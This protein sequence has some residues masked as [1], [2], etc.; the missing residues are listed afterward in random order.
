MK[1]RQAINDDAEE[2][3]RLSGQLGYPV[4]AVVMLERLN[5][6]CGDN[7]HIAYAMETNSGL[8]GWIHAQVRHTLESAPFVEIAGLVVDSNNR[9]AGI[10]R[11]L[12]IACEEWAES[13]GYSKIRVRTNHTRSE[14]VQFYSRIGFDISKTQEVL[15]KDCSEK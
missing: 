9:G 5:K 12:V 13:A 3:A 1:I 7:D 11:Q 10:G 6:I 14:A 8:L 15:D 2:I 4:D